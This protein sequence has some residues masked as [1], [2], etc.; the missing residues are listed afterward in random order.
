[1]DRCRKFGLIF[2]L[3]F[4]PI[5][6]LLAEIVPGTRFIGDLVIIGLFLWTCLEQRKL[7]TLNHSFARYY[8][9]FIGIGVLSATFTGVMPIAIAMQVRAFLIPFLL[10]FVIYEWPITKKDIQHIL[11]TSFFMGCLLSIHGLI[12]KLSART[13]LVPESWQNWEL[14]AV[15]TDRIY[16]LVANPNVLA[17]YLMIVFFLTL[18]LKELKPRYSLLFNIGLVL[19]AGAIMLTYSRGTLIAFGLS[20]FALSFLKKNWHYFIR[21]TIFFLVALA[22]IFLPIDTVTESTG[23]NTSDRFIDMFSEKRVQQSAAG[24]RVYIVKK[25][26]EIFAD[27][28]IAGIGF[29][30]Y[31]SSATISFH[32][33]IYDRYNIPN[34]L[35]ADNQYMQVLVETGIIGTFFLLLYIF[36]L[37]RKT[38]QTFLYFILI[39]GL[40]G[41][42]FY[43]MLED[44]TFTL[45]FYLIIGYALHQ[46][47][48]EHE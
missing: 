26:L 10:L 3:I 8:L 22:V 4:F 13:L 33:P 14:A 34:G 21:T 37:A 12:E 46:R 48:E 18:Y 20:L 40:I 28:P 31:G 1:M 5:R 17:V 25:G 27:Y 29:G 7:I 41:S 6:P 42:A 44:K 32:S 38:G 9:F 35:Y 23:M 11:W 45:Y 2:L 36:Q 39:A 30:T 16:G 43:S 47:R 24:G 19:L 15:N